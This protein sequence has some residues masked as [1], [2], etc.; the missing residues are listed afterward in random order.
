MKKVTSIKEMQK[1]IK[2][3]QREGRSIGLIPTM[4][5]LHEGHLTLAKKA[6][7][8][9]D[10]VVMSVFVNPLQFGEEE[11]L[12]TYPRDLERDMEL[13]AE[14]K[15]DYLFHPTAEEMYPQMQEITMNVGARTE[16][17]CGASRPGHF[18]GVVVVVS[19][20]FNIIQPE[21]AYF[22]KKDAQQFAVI[23][24]L[25]KN[26]NFPIELVAVDTVRESDGLAKSSRNVHLTAGERKEATV[27]FASLQA[28]EAIITEGEKNPSRIIDVMKTMLNEKTSGEIDYV[29]ILSYPELQPI[30]EVGGVIIIALAVKFSKARLIDNIIIT[31]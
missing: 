27:L 12:A 23:D 20:L 2:D 10:I 1:I 13:A 11:D 18:D 29:E 24:L 4:G 22:G 19:K 17:L 15:V 25:V 26:F 8:E 3:F 21:R 28:A 30:E 14:V 9:N 31:A 6:R 7:L 5:Y 16:R